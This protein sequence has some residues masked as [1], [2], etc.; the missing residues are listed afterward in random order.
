MSRE[1]TK[2]YFGAVCK[3]CPELKGERWVG[4][5]HCIGLN[6]HYTKEYW[7]TKSKQTRLRTRQLVF[8]AYGNVCSICGITDQ[9]VLT[10]DHTAQNGADHRR[11]LGFKGGGQMY[12]WLKRNNFPD[13]FR[14]LC[15][16]CNI[17]VFRQFKGY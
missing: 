5:R 1:K 2:T 6:S 3:Y 17:K 8:E 9:D 12:T 16:N 11:S 13:G 15:A 7:N 14:L 10:V 4:L